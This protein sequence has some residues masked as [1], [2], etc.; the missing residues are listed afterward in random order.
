LAPFT[1]ISPI[2]AAGH[3]MLVSG[4]TIRTVG[5]SGMP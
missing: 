4:S 5:E 1:Q 3:P 2:F